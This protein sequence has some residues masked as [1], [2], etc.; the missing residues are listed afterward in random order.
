MS[1]TASTIDWGRKRTEW[2]E[3]LRE[4]AAQIQGWCGK[5][6]WPCETI[7][8]PITEKQL[9]SYLGITLHI[10]TGTGA[11]IVEP[12]GRNIIGGEGRVDIYSVRTFARVLLIRDQDHWA[13]YTDNRVPWP[14]AWGET[15]FI[16][17]AETLTKR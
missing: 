8:T 14:E 15:A 13:L 11:L 10:H 17:L 4:L 9:G 2:E 6:V 1:Q 7:E 5:K 12:V 16:Q 3:L